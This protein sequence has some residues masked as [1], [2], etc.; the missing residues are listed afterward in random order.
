[1]LLINFRCEFLY[2]FICPRAVMYKA[3]FPATSPMLSENVM[4][5]LTSKSAPE[6]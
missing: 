3:A 5:P 2:N 4:F 6:T 1:M